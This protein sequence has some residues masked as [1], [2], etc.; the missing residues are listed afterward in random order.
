M[1]LALLSLEAA[2]ASLPLNILYDL[3]EMHTVDACIRIFEW[4]ESRSA[5][6]TKVRPSLAMPLHARS[7]TI[8]CTEYGAFERQSIGAIKATE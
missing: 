4:L 7:F 1:P 6:L 2:E 5:R 8:I 3:F